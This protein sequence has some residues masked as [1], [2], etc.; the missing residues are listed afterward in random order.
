MAP[1]CCCCCGCQG[2][3]V[4]RAVVEGAEEGAG[5]WGWGVGMGLLR[6]L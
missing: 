4:Q 5:G 6:Q 3:A 2:K 1:R